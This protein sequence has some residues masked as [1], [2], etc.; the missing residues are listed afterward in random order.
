MR[1]HFLDFDYSDD[2]E[3]TVTWDAVASVPSLRLEELEREVITVLAWAHLQFGALRGP[4]E[5]GGLWN[6]DLQ[7]ERARQPLLPLYYDTETQRLMPAP[8]A[9]PGERVTLTLSLGGGQ[10]F[11]KAF[12]THFNLR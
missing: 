4:V 10:A 8:E 3:G 2:D 6:Y 7:Y 1:L 9:S 5:S 11:S 12:A